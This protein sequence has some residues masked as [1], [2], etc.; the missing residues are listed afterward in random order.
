VQTVLGAMTQADCFW[1]DTSQVVELHVYA[2]PPA[3]RGG[4]EVQVEWTKGGCW[5]E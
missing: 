5:H 3:Q 1:W 4:V 2:M